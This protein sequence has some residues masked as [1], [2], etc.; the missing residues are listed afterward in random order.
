MKQGNTDATIF[1]STYLFI[2]CLQG[3]VDVYHIFLANSWCYLV[4]NLVSSHKNFENW[5]T[6]RE[7]VK[8]K[9]QLEKLEATKAA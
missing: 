8:K 6:V 5:C 4:E 3:V 7:P 2:Y 1:L 9:N